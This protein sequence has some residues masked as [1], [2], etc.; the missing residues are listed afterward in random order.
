[1]ANRKN[2]IPYFIKEAA[3][4]VK[5][6]I[7]SNTMSVISLSFIFFILTILFSITINL[8]TL[9][10]DLKEQAE[11]SV[12]YEENT[13]L[14]TLKTK[15]QSIAGVRNITFINQ[16]NAKKE[17][18]E[19]LGEDSKI[20][21]L[22]EYNPFSPYLEVNI[23]LEKLSEVVNEIKDTKNVTY[24]RDNKEILLKLENIMS[25]ISVFGIFILLAVSITTVF[26]TSHLI[27]QGIYINREAI[28]TL[29]LLG[30]PSK[31][32][33]FP[34]L[35]NGLFMTLFA[36]ILSIGLTFVTVSYAFKMLLSTISFIKL[37]PFNEHMVV[38][39]G[40]AILLSIVLGILGSAIGIK[41]T[42][43]KIK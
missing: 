18:V 12:F 32:I 13:D 8:Q 36:G 21:D 6:D 24:I 20:I 40:F 34:Y 42:S 43:P 26:V 5:G 28:G 11:I 29:K 2:N 4:I 16:E 15:L 39:A 38:L 27:R 35:L 17:M 22:F 7:S 41:S 3:V 31:F 25:L 10:T 37:S 33:F 30:A 23:E 14:D 9:I 1:M 19:T